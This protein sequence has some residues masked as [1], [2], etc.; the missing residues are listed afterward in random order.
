MSVHKP[1]HLSMDIENRIVIFQDY[2]KRIVTMAAAA[3]GELFA[4][5][6]TQHETWRLAPL[7]GKDDIWPTIPTPFAIPVKLIS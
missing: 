4:K 7:A 6:Q 1:R 5:Q 2:L 3:T